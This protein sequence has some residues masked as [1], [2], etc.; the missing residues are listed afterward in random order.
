MIYRAVQLAVEDCH[1]HRFLWRSDP[2]QPL[3]DFRMTR[4]TFGV[5]AS[6]FAA[7]VALKQNAFDNTVEYPLAAEVVQT[8]FYVDD[9]LTGANSVDEAI[10]LQRDFRILLGKGGFLL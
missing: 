6:P 9:G 2:D 8:S 10:K 5:S 4:I 3:Q 7:I 1:F